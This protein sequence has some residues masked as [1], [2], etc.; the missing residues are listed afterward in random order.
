MLCS[1]QALEDVGVHLVIAQGSSR[2]SPA[3]S[4]TPRMAK[5]SARRESGTRAGTRLSQECLR[6]RCSACGFRDASADDENADKPTCTCAHACQQHSNVAM[7]GQ[8]LNQDGDGEGQDKDSGW[9]S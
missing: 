6:S 7:E 3:V 1:H 4:K 8:A 9:R 2:H 5:S